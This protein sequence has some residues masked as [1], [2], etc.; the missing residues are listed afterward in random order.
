MAIP[1]FLRYETAV[2]NRL[3]KGLA[4]QLELQ[5]IHPGACKVADQRQAAD[6]FHV[7]EEVDLLQA[8]GGDAGRRADDQD[9]TAGAGAVGKELPQEVV[10]REI[11]QAVHAH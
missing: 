2:R 9:R 1:A 4:Q 8:H 7:P 6:F 10:G 5:Q 11:A 3:G